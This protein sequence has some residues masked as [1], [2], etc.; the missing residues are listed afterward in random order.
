MKKL[1]NLKFL[2]TLVLLSLSSNHAYSEPLSQ[3]M[4][5][6]GMAQNVDSI[7]VSTS[8]NGAI[9]LYKNDTMT[10]VVDIS[11]Q[12]FCLISIKKNNVELTTKNKKYNLNGGRIFIKTID[13]DS[14][15]AGLVFGGNHWYRGSLEIFP[16]LKSDKSLTMVNVLPLEEYLYGVVPSEMPSSWPMEALKTQAIAARTYAL[17]HLGQFSSDGFDIMP[18]TASQVYGGVEEETPVTN[19]AVNETR[20]KVITY[21]AKLISAYYSSGGGGI[22]ESGLDA[23]GSYIPYLKSVRDYDQDSPRYIWYKNISNEEIQKIIKR[24]YATETGE[25]TKIFI[26]ESTQSGRAKTIYFEGTKT[27]LTID[28]KKWRLSAK[29]NSTLF[30]VGPVDSGTVIIDDT[31]HIPTLFIFTGR[32]FG[33]G[34][35]MSQWGTRFLAKNGRSYQDIIKYYYQGVQIIDADKL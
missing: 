24:D 18:T 6:V 14:R 27:G 7:P 15:Y 1:F 13:E 8:S 10:K 4:I 23:W 3:K 28:A 25:I 32:G 5:K 22:T 16:S 12:Q 20:G 19:Q 29:L 35:G 2:S 11:S 17:S 33:H 21:N 31:K 34:A 9:Y 26:A 30:K